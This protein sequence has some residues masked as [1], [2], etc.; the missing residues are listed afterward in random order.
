M[1]SRASASVM[2]IVLGLAFFA[3]A[4]AV[5]PEPVGYVTRIQG[6]ARARPAE[7]PDA[8]PRPLGLGKPVHAGDHLATEAD[9]RLEIRLRNGVMVTLGER[10]EFTVQAAPAAGDDRAQG[11]LMDL[12]RGVFRAITPKTATEIPAPLQV[13][14]SVA[15]IGIR[16]TDFWG[17][18]QFQ[19]GALDVV[20]LAGKGVYVETPAGRVELTVPGEGTTV[21]DPA[22]PPAPP[23]SWPAAKLRAAQDSVAWR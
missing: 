3:A 9:T 20:M 1:Q 2:S 14:T 11:T 5:A 22:Q 8:A 7:P 16:G 18:F 13:R 23:K 4:W 21:A 19:P 12:T 17:G 10:T 15:V 6:V